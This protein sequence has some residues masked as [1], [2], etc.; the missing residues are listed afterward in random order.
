MKS[1]LEEISK[2]FMDYGATTFHSD[3]KYAH[4]IDAVATAEEILLKQ[5]NDDEES[6]FKAFCKA[7]STVQ[8]MDSSNMFQSGFKM[9][10]LIMLEILTCNDFH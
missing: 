5:L 4:A 9:G 1:I 8:L 3:S 2:G 7:E 10:A 6:A